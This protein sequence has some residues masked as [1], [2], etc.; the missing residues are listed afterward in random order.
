MFH[1]SL[2]AGGGNQE[3]DS[4]QAWH[5]ELEGKVETL[6]SG[7]DCQQYQSTKESRVQENAE[8]RGAD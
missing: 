8:P 2:S 4:T 7:R 6:T 3:R 5:K 1:L